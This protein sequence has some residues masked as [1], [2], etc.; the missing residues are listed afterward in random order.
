MDNN[1]SNRRKILLLGKNGQVGWELQRTLAPL[2][3][4]MALDQEELDLGRV[5]DVRSTMQ[6]FKPDIIVNAA[7]YTAVD[8]AVSE[9]D[10]AMAIN[11]DAPGVLAEEA[12]KLGALLVH[13]STDYVFD[14]TKDT[15][16]TEEDKP[17]PLN[18]YGKTKLAGEQAI[19]AVDGNHLIFR[20]SWVYGTRGQ[21]FF[22]TM[23]RLARE[24][25]EIRVVDD[26]IGAP[27]W[28]RMIAESTALILAQGVNREE[29]FNGYF[30]EKKGIYHMTAG[31]QTSWYGFAERIFESTPDSYRK[32]KRLI[33]IVSREY[34]TAAIR[35]MS[36]ILDNKKVEETY[37][38]KI[39]NWN[40]FLIE[41]DSCYR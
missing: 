32:L 9:P 19:Q 15:P 17:N 24:R 23:L 38:I 4:V 22:L 14:G 11:G 31:G 13:Y 33:P 27:T 20:T 18:V 3:N 30:E 21:N 41:M 37:G 2:G 40:R 7:A 12:K 28:C 10:L 34:P 5:G 1:E 39:R 6:E 16:Y 36:S 25:E 8:K 35:P 29:G 26:Q